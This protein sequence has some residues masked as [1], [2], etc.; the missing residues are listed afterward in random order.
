MEIRAQRYKKL[1]YN[2]KEILS[3]HSEDWEH[4][5]LLGILKESRH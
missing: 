2:E 5:D 1:I 4:L 3:E